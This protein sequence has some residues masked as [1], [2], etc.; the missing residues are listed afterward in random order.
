MCL[1][2]NLPRIEG[3][4][5]CRRLRADGI[6]T[7][8]LMLTARDAIDD[9]IAGLDTGADDYLGTSFAFGELLARMRAATCT[10]ATF[11]VTTR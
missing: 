2:V 4:E 10:S 1:D 9:R 6:T 8:I 7:P 5:T 3:L 11:P